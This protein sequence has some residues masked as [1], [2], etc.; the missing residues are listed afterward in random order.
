MVQPPR[1][2]PMP[3]SYDDQLS[4][5]ISRG[6]V[7][8][9]R[10]H[11]DSVFWDNRADRPSWQ[12]LKIALMREDVPMMR[13]LA[14][15]G[16]RPSD[17]D[18]AQ[19]KALAKD[20]YADYL[21]LLRQCGLRGMNTDW[22]QLP[23]VEAPVAKPGAAPA[24]EPLDP[25][26]RVPA[27]WLTVLKAFHAKGA[28]EA[29]IAGGALRDTFNGGKVKD[30]DI[31]LRARGNQKSHKALLEQVFAEAGINVVEQATGWSGYSR[32]V[33]A[34]PTPETTKEK[35]SHAFGL[36]A[37]RQSESWTVIAGPQKT[38]YNIIFIDDDVDRKMTAASPRHEQ[39]EIF[40]AGLLAAFDIGLC[41][42]ATDGISV[43]STKEYKQDVADKTISLLRPNESSEDHLRRVV[44]KYP[45]WKLSPAAQEALKPMAAP[46]SR[47]G[48]GAIRRKSSY[49]Y[50]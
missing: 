12:H 25:I 32:I 23:A 19:F 14:T 49:S 27:E 4:E 8:Q 38:E 40:A 33:A 39:R 26:R 50:Y 30:V 21:R 43:V 44:K 13:L 22:A 11:F 47:G 28:D 46:V 48:Y 35:L 36:I 20:K 6:T 18:M 15:W 37:K 1:P 24:A 2:W 29:V 42:I 34:F 45:E 10:D 9:V 5:I 16:A 7:Q 31:F 17:D 41:Q 3:T